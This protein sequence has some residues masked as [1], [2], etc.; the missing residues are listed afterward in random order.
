MPGT[1]QK[2]RGPAMTRFSV[3]CHK[4]AVT[5]SWLVLLLAGGAASGRLSGHLSHDFSFPNT[6]A[7]KANHAFLATYGNGASTYRWF[8]WLSCPTE[9]PSTTR[10]SS[11]RSTYRGH[12]YRD[13]GRSRPHRAASHQRR[14]DPVL[15]LRC[16]SHR[17]G[18]RHQDPGNR[19]GRE[20]PARR[21]SGTQP[22]RTGRG[23]AVRPWNWWLPDWARPPAARAGDG[24]PDHIHPRPGAPRRLRLKP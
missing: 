12:P 4:L 14:A 17:T 11:R 9:A 16:A 24:I 7:D 2:L 23:V 13:R 6:A 15:R 10:R 1:S 19:T 21:D 8:P 18:H 20:H 3:L 22:A 5:L